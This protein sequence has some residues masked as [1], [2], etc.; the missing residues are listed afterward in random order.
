MKNVFLN[1]TFIKITRIISALICVTCVIIFAACEFRGFED[2]SF[3]KRLYITGLDDGW[4]LTVDGE[5]K[6]LVDL[7][8]KLYAAPNS[9]IVLERKLPLHIAEH[10]CFFTRSSRQNMWIYIDGDLRQSYLAERLHYFAIDPPSTNIFVDLTPE[11]AGKTVRIESCCSFQY[12]GVL[13]NAKIGSSASLWFSEIENYAFVFIINCVVFAIGLIV[14]VMCMFLR[15]RTHYKSNLVY[16]GLAMSSIALWE[17]FESRLRPLLF[18]MPSVSGLLSIVLLCL[19]SVPVFA[20]WDLIQKKRYTVFYN[21]LNTYFIALC[22]C[23][24]SLFFLKKADLFVGIN[25]ILFG[26]G[27]GIALILVTTTIELFRG[28]TKEYKFSAFGV[29][30]VA[31]AGILEILSEKVLPNFF[32]SG[33]FLSF[34]VLFFLFMSIIQSFV[35]FMKNFEE[36]VRQKDRITLNTIKTIIAALDAKDKYT[37]GHS[38]R[39]ASYA[40]VLAEALGKDKKYV[41]DI[42]LMGLMHDIGKIGVSDVILNKSSKLSDD[43]YLFMRQHTVIGAQLLTYVENLEGLGDAVLFHHERYDGKGYPKGLVAEQIP[44]IARILCIADTYD[45]MTSNRVYRDRLSNE[46]VRE[47]LLNNAGKQFDPIMVKLFVSLVDSGKIKPLTI[48][49]F[50]K[51]ESDISSEIIALQKFMQK[52]PPSRPEFLRMI[53]YLMKL[54]ESK[55]LRQCTVIFS[56]TA[57]NKTT[58]AFDEAL[59]ASEL[60]INSIAP[61]LGTSGISSLYSPAKR[62]AVFVGLSREEEMKVLEDIKRR[63]ASIDENNEFDF[64]YEII[65]I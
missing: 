25:F 51:D 43:E 21:I 30:A 19:M 29:F 60:L 55:N 7:P 44:E 56:A 31:C 35:D 57:K 27:F 40:A 1:E 34:S 63:F 54:N 13:N 36:Q 42:H 24:L 28:K 65:C 53:I 3:P 49:G 2:D 45:V 38:Y 6:G 47:E 48:D 18:K 64:S 10:D 14:S 5:E 15:Y 61:S 52:T 22:L 58:V 20:Y 62:I 4:H 16:L 46:E 37:G 50:E 9:K 59:F 39:V 32:M 12:S 23:L 8:Q 26:M 17:I 41:E 33:S 11:D